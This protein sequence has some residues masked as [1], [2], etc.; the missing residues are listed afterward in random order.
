MPPLNSSFSTGALSSFFVARPRPELKELF[1]F[2]IIFAFANSIVTIFEPVFFYT[3]G[4]SLSFIALY[5]FLHYTL[6]VLLMPFGGKFAARFGLERSLAVSLPFFVMYFLALASIPSWPSFVWLAIILLTLHKVFYWPA[7]HAD[8]AKFG[9]VNNR[10][11]ELSWMGLLKTG[12]G[13]LGPLIGGFVALYLGFPVLFV[14]AAVLILLSVYPLL[15]T[16]EHYHM[17]AF[18]YFMPWRI[19]FDRRFRNMTLAMM[20]MGENLIDLVFWPL[21]MF[22]ILGTT[23]KLGIVSSITVGAMTLVGFFIGEL[24][25]RYPRRKILRQWLPVMIAGILLRPLAGTSLQVLVTDAV[26][27][28]A[29]AGVS[30]PMLYRLYVQSRRTSILGY[31]VAFELVLAVTKAV[32]ALALV[33]VFA[34]ALPYTAFTI[35]F[36]AAA[37]FAVMYA[38]L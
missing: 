30:L 11:T 16:K 6:Y 20:G 7:Y 28:I 24:S 33:I 9:D 23:G 12:V 4:F 19:V 34:T 22:I 32:V 18:D 25:D 27:R 5:Y 31:T 26:N 1:F 21:F 10:G 13:I 29:Y 38:F 17:R 14:L 2:S 15:R 3:N 37:V 35:T 8:F 36:I